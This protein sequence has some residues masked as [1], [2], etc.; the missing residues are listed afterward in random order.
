M[1]VLS[2]WSSHDTHTDLAM[3]HCQSYTVVR[4]VDSPS[5]SAPGVRVVENQ[6]STDIGA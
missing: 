6:H 5:P 4:H 2:I 3:S 1:A